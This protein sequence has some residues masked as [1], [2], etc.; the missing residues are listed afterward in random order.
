V[1]HRVVMPTF[2]SLALILDFSL[3]LLPEH[4]HFQGPSYSKPHRPLVSWCECQLGMPIP[5]LSMGVGCSYP[6]LLKRGTVASE[7]NDRWGIA[8]GLEKI[9]FY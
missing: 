1:L 6:V 3:L 7:V 4:K 9:R 8:R 2:L 5:R